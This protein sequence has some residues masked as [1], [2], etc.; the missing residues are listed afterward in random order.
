MNPPQPPRDRNTGPSGQ[1]AAP[2]PTRS[3]VQQIVDEQKLQKTEM[4]AALSTGPKRRSLGPAA[5]VV[6]VLLN[7]VGWFIIPPVGNKSGDL[8]AA[9]E[10]ERD[11]RVIVASAASGIEVWRR[12]NDGRLPGSLAEAGV[13]DPGLTFT[14]LDSATYEIRGEHRGAAV[15]YRSTLTLGDFLDS[16]VGVRK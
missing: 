8:R 11:L 7:L 16:G 1:P 14:K 4:K 3:L 6:L 2:P 5:A 13:T 9:A 15:T 10:V 12:T